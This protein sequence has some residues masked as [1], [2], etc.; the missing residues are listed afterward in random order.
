MQICRI[1]IAEWCCL[2]YLSPTRICIN[3]W[4][5]VSFAHL[6]QIRETWQFAKLNFLKIYYNIYLRVNYHTILSIITKCLMKVASVTIYIMARQI[7]LCINLANWRNV[8]TV[9]LNFQK[10]LIL[11]PLTGLSI[12]Y[13]WQTTT[14]Q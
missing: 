2:F 14:P 4:Q 1:I 3:S 12:G 6:W 10:I 7:V 13:Y 11:A 8:Y 9:K 5:I